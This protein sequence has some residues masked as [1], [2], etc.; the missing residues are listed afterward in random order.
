[1]AAKNS[2]TRSAQ[3][4]SSRKVG[5][6]SIRTPENAKAV[7]DLIASGNSLRQIG[8][9]K[10]MPSK[11][12][13]VEWLNEDETFA[14]QY[15]R[16]RA[17]QAD[18]QFD[19]IQEISDEVPPLVDGKMDSAFVAWQRNRVDVRKWRMSKLLPKKYGDKLALTDP[20][21]EGPLQVVIQRFAAE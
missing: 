19:E 8:K 20:T 3:Q 21:G 16:A 14:A 1:M 10:G 18:H 13:I 6:P 4:P 17:E 11:P 2:A 12:A 15:A 7:C 5:R 9:I